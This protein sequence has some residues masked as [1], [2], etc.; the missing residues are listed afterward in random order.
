M[1][2]KELKYNPQSGK[3]MVLCDFAENYAFVLQDVA[4][5]FHWNNPQAT[6]HL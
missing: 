4:H 1:F 3:F 5:R 6:I 2:L